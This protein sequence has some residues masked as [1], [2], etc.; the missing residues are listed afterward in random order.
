MVPGTVTGTGGCELLQTTLIAAD[1]G[2]AGPSPNGR[3]RGSGSVKDQRPQSYAF[4]RHIGRSGRVFRYLAVR[5]DAGFSVETGP[6]L[7]RAA[8]LFA[9]VRFAVDSPLEGGRI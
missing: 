7:R 9:T 2:D 1:R 5:Q 8:D 6:Q 3:M 4:A